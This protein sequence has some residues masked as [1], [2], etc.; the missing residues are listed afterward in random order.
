MRAAGTLASLCIFFSVLE[1][2]PWPQ[3][4]LGSDSTNGVVRLVTAPFVH[5]FGAISILPHLAGNLLLLLFV[6]SATERVLGT[7]R[8]VLLT[9]ASLSAYAVIQILFQLEVNGASV[10]IWAYAPALAVRYGSEDRSAASGPI[11]G[12]L[13]V[14]WIIVPT[15]MTAVPY[16]FGWSGSLFGAFIVANAFHLSATATGAAAAWWWRDRLRT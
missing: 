5:G 2:L 8:F 9:V 1:L 16:A 13:V 12:V 7:G 11:L 10:F 15:V 6:G 3:M 4:E 14:M